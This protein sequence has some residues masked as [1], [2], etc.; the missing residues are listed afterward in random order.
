MELRPRHHMG[1]RQRPPLRLADR[2]HRRGYMGGHDR[3]AARRG[4]HAGTVTAGRGRRHRATR[5]HGCRRV[6]DRR[7][8][9]RTRRTV[10]RR[11]RRRHGRTHHRDVGPGPHRHRRVAVRRRSGAVMAA[12]PGHADTRRAAQPIMRRRAPIRCRSHARRHPVRAVRRSRWCTRAADGAHRFDHRDRDGARAKRAG[13]GRVR[14]RSRRGGPA[15][16]AG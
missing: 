1:A 9:G 2:S 10:A 8:P 15:R 16:P 13:A 14:A 11:P 6:R 3:P 4:S 5:R 12:R 7:A